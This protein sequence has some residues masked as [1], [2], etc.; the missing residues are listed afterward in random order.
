MMIHVR[1][2]IVLCLM[3]VPF[4]TGCENLIDK[5][6]YDYRDATSDTVI[7]LPNDY[8]LFGTLNGLAFIKKKQEDSPDKID[9]DVKE[10]GWDDQFILYKRERLGGKTEAGILNVNT[11]ELTILSEEESLENQLKKIGVS[12]IMLKLFRLTEISS[13]SK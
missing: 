8:R 4:L 11:D 12:H 6:I 3:I 9:A 7:V 1:R 2:L 10:L 5:A 13:S